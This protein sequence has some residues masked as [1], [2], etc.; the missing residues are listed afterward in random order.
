ML[1]LAVGVG[2]GIGRHGAAWLG[3][4]RR[5]AETLAPHQRRWFAWFGIRDVGSPFYLA[6]A[7]HHHVVP[8]SIAAVVAEAVLIAI[9][10]KVAR[11]TGSRRHR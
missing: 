1:Y 6:F 4:V 9:A 11:S 7:L 10:M 3:V 5:R 2:V 8:A